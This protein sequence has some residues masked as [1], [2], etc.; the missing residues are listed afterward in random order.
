MADYQAGLKISLDDQLS[1][2]AQ[3]AEDRLNKLADAADKAG[4]STDDLQKTTERVGPSFEVVNRKIDENAKLTQQ[5]DT[6][7]QIGRAHV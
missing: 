2:G 5:L 3:A 6:I 1:S 4:K 7:N